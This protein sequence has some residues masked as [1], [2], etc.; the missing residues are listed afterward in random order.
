[1]NN[2]LVGLAGVAAAVGAALWG[3]AQMRAAAPAAASNDL[4][5][6]WQIATSITEL[7]TVA[8]QRPPLKP[9]A[10]AEYEQHIAAAQAG[11]RSWDPVSK[12]KP[13]GEPRTFMLEE[14]F[15]LFVS[16]TRSDFLFQ[17][18]RLDH[19]IPML[20]EHGTQ[21]GPFYFGESIGQWDGRTLSVDII[22]LKPNT[23][24]DPSGLPH[25]DNLHLTEQFTLG[26]D[27]NTLVALIHVDDPD[28]YTSAWDAQL[29]FKRVSNQRIVE[30][31]CME[32]LK[33]TNDYYMLDN[34]L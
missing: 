3:M 34:A 23:F 6:M 1:M 15:E 8:G 12:C 25:S 10:L 33:L 30:D 21:Y 24:L 14:P 11:D 4:S 9:E 22:N 31:V 26:A 27:G 5:G 29:T 28:V 16:E 7:K 2:K 18:N 17:W 32:R 13:P 20:K 19:A